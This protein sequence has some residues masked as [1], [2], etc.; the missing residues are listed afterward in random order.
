M[1]WVGQ[2]SIVLYCVHFPVQGLS[3]LALRDLALSAPV[4]FVL[5]QVVVGIGVPV[6]VLWGYRYTKILFELPA[7]PRIE[8]RAVEQAGPS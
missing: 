5:V 4:L 7:L 2:K 3:A 1:E 8:R 6:L